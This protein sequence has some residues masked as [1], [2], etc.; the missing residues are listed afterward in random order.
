MPP[1]PDQLPQPDRDQRHRRDSPLRGR[2][3]TTRLAGRL[4]AHRPS[5]NRQFNRIAIRPTT[6][7]IERLAKA[8]R[9]GVIGQAHQP[10]GLQHAKVYLQSARLASV[11]GSPRSKA[12]SRGKKNRA[13]R[14][15]AIAGTAVGHAQSPWPSGLAAKVAARAGWASIAAAWPANLSQ[16][17]SPGSKLTLQP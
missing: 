12:G 11:A 3:A 16:S 2:Y 1:A 4:S 8:T 9:H 14:A 15:R 6:P 7:A 13:T 10:P 17:M 5:S